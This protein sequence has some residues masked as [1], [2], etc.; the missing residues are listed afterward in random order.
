MNDKILLINPKIGW[1]ESPAYDRVW[2]PLSLA[3]CAAVLEKNGFVVE[4]VDA[5]AEKLNSEDIIKKS[6]HFGKVFITTS[7][8]DKWQCPEPNIK[9]TLNLIKKIRAVNPNTYLIGSHGTA[10]PNEI[11][12]LTNVK[13]IIRR[14]PE[15]TVL[16]ICKEKNIRKI[17]GIT[18]KENGKIISNPDRPLLD[19]NKLPLPAFHLLPMKKYFYEILGN[20]FTLFEGSRGCPFSCAY[21][22]KSMYGNGYRKKSSERLINEV[23]YAIENFGVKTAYF[24][25]LEFCINRNL[26]EKLCDFLIR[27]KY[28]FKWACQTRFDTID[29]K[30]LKKM[31]RAGCE[32]IHFGVESGSPR[33]LK[34]MNKKISINQIKNGMKLV[35]KANIKSVCFFMFGLPTETKNEMEM[36]IK[37]A[38]EINPTY[39][40]FHVAT[41]Y[42]KTEF[43][44]M[45]ENEVKD[46]FPSFYGNKEEL[47]NVVKGAYKSFYLR[48]QYIFS[49][50]KRGELK[51]LGK[52]IKLFLRLLNRDKA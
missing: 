8:L 47:E 3:Y 52:Q 5:N 44:S 31:K 11:L 42:P 14:E 38:K 40:S 13:A 29:F 15:F 51:M 46:L 24:I 26:V 48:P 50:L 27:K 19:L 39:A 43:Y 32:V 34:M 49:R 21:C 28:D 10:K 20:N 6:K 18:Y 9:P 37:F 2:P 4:I 25:D 35:K 23:K 41:P 45:I 33:I 12:K 17:K 22:F 16:E 1:Y 36:T 30:L 7:P